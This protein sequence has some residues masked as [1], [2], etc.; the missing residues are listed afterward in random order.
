M[1]VCGAVGGVGVE[2][3]CLLSKEVVSIMLK[4]WLIFCFDLI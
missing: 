3:D 2:G 1:V 4:T